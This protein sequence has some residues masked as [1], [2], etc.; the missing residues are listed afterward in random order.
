MSMEYRVEANFGGIW[1]PASS[2]H[3]DICKANESLC[4]FRKGNPTYKFR[5]A[6]RE[7]GD[8][9]ECRDG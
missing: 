4:L 7:V 3:N 8:W 2:V 9:C 1:K 5:L 6:C